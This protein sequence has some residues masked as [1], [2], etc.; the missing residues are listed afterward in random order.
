MLRFNTHPELVG[1]HAFLSP[2]NHSWQRYTPE[3]LQQVFLNDRKKQQ[4]TRIHEFVSEAINLRMKLAPFKKSPNQFVNDAIG[5]KMQSE[6]PLYYSDYIFGTA[7]AILYDEEQ[8]LL[9]I[10]D[11]KTGD[12][13]VTNFD[14]LNAYAALFMLEYNHSPLDVR[15][16]ERL[17][18]DGQINEYEPDPD[19]IASLMSQII[20]LSK[21][22]EGM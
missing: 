21:T 17:Y 16:V 10:H 12:R 11:L 15:V 14:Q 13:P 9:R 19:E 3:K 18:Q 4:G 7:D 20:S 6:V 8:Q 1:H 22:L 2:S 5:F